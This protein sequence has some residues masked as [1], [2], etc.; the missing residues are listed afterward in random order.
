[1]AKEKQS[2]VGEEPKVKPY[3]PVLAIFLIGLIG[4]TIFSGLIVGGI[5]GVQLLGEKI[6]MRNPVKN[7]D[8]TISPRE[9]YFLD[10]LGGA[11]GIVLGFLADGLCIEKINMILKYNKFRKAIKH[12]L[13]NIKKEVENI[14]EEGDKVELRQVQELIIDDVV[15]NAE[16]VSLIINLP[17]ASHKFKNDMID[18]LAKIHNGIKYLNK[19]QEEASGKIID[20]TE[21]NNLKSVILRAINKILGLIIGVN[22]RYI[23]SMLKVI[24]GE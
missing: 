3:H 12:E 16:T 23:L 21:I 7:S 13:E 19:L 24:H 2:T 10:F 17:L 18:N 11:L 15:K 6:A 8:G 20:D 5:F 14:K 1:M 4:L 9:L 22:I